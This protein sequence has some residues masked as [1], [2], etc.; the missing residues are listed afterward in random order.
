MRQVVNVAVGFIVEQHHQ[1]LCSKLSKLSQLI[2]Q[3]VIE[4]PPIRWKINLSARLGVREQPVALKSGSVAQH[5]AEL[6]GGSF[7]AAHGCVCE[8]GWIDTLVG[9]DLQFLPDAFDARAG[10]V[11]VKGIGFPPWG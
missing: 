1:L 9:K 3:P 6:S 7:H 11:G 5:R 10:L 8:L 2:L 4:H